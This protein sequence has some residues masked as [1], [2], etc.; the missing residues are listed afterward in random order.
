MF[1]YGIFLLFFLISLCANALPLTVGGDEISA[2][3]NIARPSEILQTVYEQENPNDYQKRQI[4]G[5]VDEISK[6]AAVEKFDSY[7]SLLRFINSNFGRRQRN[8]FLLKEA[9]AEKEGQQPEGTLDCD[10]K[11]ILALAVIEKLGYP[12]GKIYLADQY[13]HVILFYGGEYFDMTLDETV[14]PSK[15]DILKTNILNS[16]AKVRSL[17]MGTKAAYEDYY[18]VNVIAGREDKERRAA[19]R[20]L[21]EQSIELD[22]KN[23]TALHNLSVMT[24][25]IKYRAQIAGLMMANY[26]DLFA[27][28][29][30]FTVNPEMRFKITQPDKAVEA[31]KNSEA[32]QKEVYEVMAGA[33]YRDNYEAAFKTGQILEKAGVSM[34]GYVAGFQAKALFSM[35]RYD[36]AKAYVNKADAARYKDDFPAEL[37]ADYN[38][39]F[40]ELDEEA[41]AAD[42]LQGKI[43]AANIK[44]YEGRSKIIDGILNGGR[45]NLRYI[46]PFERIRQ[47]K[48]CAAFIDSLGALTLTKKENFCN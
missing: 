11:S 43:T 34:Y 13:S 5:L 36:E 27:P 1:K 23:I 3:I 42:I 39:V 32:I 46:K 41:Y 9:F 6:K 29:P 4:E 30:L 20:K 40:G 28:K 24:D 7:T 14:L 15:D 35:G 31:V 18:S 37:V 26:F 44:K 47:W 10:S 16:P 45:V 8:T 19:A 12:F 21:M 22:P 2:K 33:Y 17:I 48:G 38:Y 25:D